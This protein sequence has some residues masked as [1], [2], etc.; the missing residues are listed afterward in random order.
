M[1]PVMTREKTAKTTRMTKTMTQMRTAKIWGPEDGEEPWGGHGCRGACHIEVFSL[2]LH[3]RSQ[4]CNMNHVSKMLSLNCKLIKIMGSTIQRRKNI[5][6]PL[7]CA[8]INGPT[9]PVHQKDGRQHT[10][11]Y[12]VPPCWAD[13][14]TG[15]LRMPSL[16]PFADYFFQISRSRCN[17]V[18]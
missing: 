4:I 11:E 16:S 13:I 2:S 3:T 1:L 12:N 9:I 17:H 10:V 6:V 15:H 7:H 14:P 18:L 8:S 5:L